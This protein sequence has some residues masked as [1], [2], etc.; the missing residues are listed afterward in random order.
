V[1]GESSGNARQLTFLLQK[2]DAL[3]MQVVQ[4]RA[5]RN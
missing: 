3:G 2:H 4:V 5:L 1:L